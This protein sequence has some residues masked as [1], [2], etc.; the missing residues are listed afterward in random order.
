[1]L[2]SF[3]YLVFVLLLELL[4]GCRRDPWHEQCPLAPRESLAA[5]L[6]TIWFRASS[7]SL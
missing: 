5:G 4:I 6:L 2:F 7:W 3:I 1:M